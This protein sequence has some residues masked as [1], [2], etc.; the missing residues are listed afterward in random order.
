[1]TGVEEVNQSVIIELQH[2]TAYT[3]TELAPGDKRIPVQQ[4]IYS[5]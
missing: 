1:M 3:E 5:S 2:I 4:L